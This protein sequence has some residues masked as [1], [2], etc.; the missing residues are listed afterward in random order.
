MHKTVLTNFKSFEKLLPRLNLRF[1][2]GIY[3][4]KYLLLDNISIKNEN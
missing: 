2:Y 3:I 1:I 4:C